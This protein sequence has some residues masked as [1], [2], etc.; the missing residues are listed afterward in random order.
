MKVLFW[1]SLALM[2]APG[3][4][5]ARAHEA[6]SGWT[7]PLECCHSLDCAEVAGSTVR[8]TPTGYVI[9]VRPGS[10]P[11][12]RADRAEPLTV[13]FPYRQAKPSPD[14]KWHLC[15]DST[16][17]PLCFFAIIGGT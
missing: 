2:L 6:M 11:M 1:L 13:T 9:T 5:A 3:A 8:E 15:I 16:G 14:G 17:K 7:Y 10:H 12:W 4:D